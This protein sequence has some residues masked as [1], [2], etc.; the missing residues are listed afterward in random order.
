[1]KKYTNV[2]ILLVATCIATSACSS[3]EEM[4]K[5][6]VDTTAPN[7]A[8]TLPAN[9]AVG[10]DNV[11]SIVITYDD[12]IFLPPETTIK[13]NNDY[14]DSLAYAKDNKLI[15]K[16]Q[17]TGNTNY[18]IRIYSPSVRDSLMNFARDYE[19]NFST[20]SY[21][22][23]DAALFKLDDAPV[24][25][26]ATTQTVKLYRFL[27][28][29]FGK[30]TISGAMADVSLNTKMAEK[31]HAM[32]GK[33]PAINTFDFIHHTHSAPL[34][35]T[36]WIDYTNTSLV[37]DWWNHNGIVSFMWHWNVPI[38][39]LWAGDFGKYSFRVNSETEPNTKF[40]AA[41]AT[42]EGTWEKNIT[43]RDLNIIADYL[44]SLQAK[45]IP[46]LWRPMHEGAGNIYNYDSGKAWF[47]WG[48]GGETTQDHAKAYRDLWIYMFNFFRNKG[49][50]NLLWVWT[51]E[52]KDADFYPGDKYVDI[53]GRDYYEQE[54]SHYH[55]SLTEQWHELLAISNKKIV[56]LTE[57]GAIPSIDNTRQ[58]GDL[59]SWFMPWY[60]NYTT[61]GIYN[62]AD[63]MTLLMDSQHVITRD[64]MPSLK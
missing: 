16:Y 24:N 62:S 45:G 20:R 48:N 46:V 56:A 47:W 10:I 50:N 27:K 21:N 18:T 49:V 29:N 35:P 51:S 52:G 30:R 12:A 55:A 59:W 37:E 13:I 1:M 31:I 43:D 11:D 64:E 15:I 61:D 39:K 32:T 7:V 40:D 34:N 36:T 26:N 28:E 54:T 19:F 42:R 41:N 57:C 33:Y 25:P 44:L 22:N 3:N 23:F 60:G 9:E 6:I 63:F 8:S 53:I 14:V 4:E 38:N 5:T 58:N 17:T 2:L